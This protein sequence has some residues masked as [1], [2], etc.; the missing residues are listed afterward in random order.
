[1]LKDFFG[2]L[3]ICYDTYMQLSIVSFLDDE[4][5]RKVKDLQIALSEVTGSKAS[6]FSWSPH[7]TLADGVELSGDELEEFVKE[8]KY[9]ADATPAFELDIAGFDSLDSR[10]IGDGEV[11][12]PY[13]IYIDVKM[14]QDLIDLVNN[15]RARITSYPKWYSMPQP[16]LPHI[17][18]A[19]RDLSEDGFV[20]GLKY[21]EGKSIKLSSHINHIALVQKLEERDQ[22]YTRVKLKN[23]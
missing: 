7:I 13:L 9:I 23:C 22:E 4:V 16:Y 1:M 3:F 15:L 20:A 11:S 12:T 5:T 10:P 8:L 17:T 19:F 18:L 2:S 21:L 6:L 14:N